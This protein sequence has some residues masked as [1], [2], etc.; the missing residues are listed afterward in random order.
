MEVKDILR[1]GGLYIYIY[2]YKLKKKSDLIL[3]SKAKIKTKK[4]NIVSNILNSFRIEKTRKN[5]NI[6]EMNI[7]NFW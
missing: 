2:L 7:K 4:S 6:L 3:R 5:I 1:V